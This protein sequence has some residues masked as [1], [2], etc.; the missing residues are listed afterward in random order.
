EEI[1]QKQS[2]ISNSEICEM[3]VIPFQFHQL[4]YN[5]ITNSLKF[6]HPERRLH[7]NISSEHAKGKR[8]ENKNLDGDKFYCHITFADNGIGFEPQYN[9]K[10]FELFQRLHGKSN[11]KGTEIELA[12]VKRIIENHDGFITAKGE[13][14]KGAMF[15]I[16]LPVERKYLLNR[17]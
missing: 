15:D 16:Y 8:F 9:E 13:A 6:S 5:L 12:I 3:N 7:I 17:L 11:Y 1:Q 2:T 4:F 10:I 14:G